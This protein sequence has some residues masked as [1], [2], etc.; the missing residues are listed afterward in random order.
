MSQ[1]NYK[2]INLV[3]NLTFKLKFMIKVILISFFVGVFGGNS[4][5]HFIKGI[6]KERYPS[7]FGNSSIPNFMAGWLGLNITCVLVYFWNFKEYPLL[8]FF[9]CSLGLLL[10]GLFHAGPGAFGKKS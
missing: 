9:L 5:P 4:I 10:I 7:V 3:C 1:L 2:K 6:T 8:S